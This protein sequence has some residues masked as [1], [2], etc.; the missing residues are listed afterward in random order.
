[1]FSR[2]QGERHYNARLNEDAVRDIRTRVAEG[3]TQVEMA[4]KYNVSKLCVSLVVRRLSWRHVKDMA[5][6][7]ELKQ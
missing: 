5:P 2:N 3:A 1:V 6:T 4:E 7:A